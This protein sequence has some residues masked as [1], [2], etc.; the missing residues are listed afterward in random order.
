MC[1]FSKGGGGKGSWI[2]ISMETVDGEELYAGYP[3]ANVEL[4]GEVHSWLS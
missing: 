1:L 4:W 2:L 3:V